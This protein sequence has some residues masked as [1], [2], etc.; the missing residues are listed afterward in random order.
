MLKVFCA[1]LQ[2]DVCFMVVTN[3]MKTNKT[4][5]CQPRIGFA[6][7]KFLVGVRIRS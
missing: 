2:N 6:E 7:F 3:G 4:W 5:N 1:A